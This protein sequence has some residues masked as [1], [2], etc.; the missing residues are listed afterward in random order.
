MSI[1]QVKCREWGLTLA[2]GALFDLLNQASSWA[3]AHLIDGEVYYWVSRNK[4]LD[5]IPVAYN[6]ADT[7]YRSLKDLEAKGLIIYKKEGRKD[8]VKLSEKGKTWNV[9]G[10]AQGDEKLGNKSDFAQNSE[11]NPSKLG[12]KSDL[13][14]DLNPTDKS[15]NNKSTNI[16]NIEFDVFWNLYNKKTGR[17]AC[18]KKWLRLKDDEREAVIKHLPAYIAST[19][20]VKYRKNPL[21][22]LNGKHWQD[23]VIDANGSQAVTQAPANAPVIDLSK[24]FAHLK[25]RG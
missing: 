4:V 9:K 7:V 11:I 23:E 6:K 13:N 19:P 17:A 2:Q 8:L 18:E 21:T 3:K 25:Q 12:N 5:E 22:Y 10:T 20:D 16:I 14:S 1:N 15:T 24:R